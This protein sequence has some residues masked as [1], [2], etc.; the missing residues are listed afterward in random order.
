MVC[1]AVGQVGGDTK[2]IIL[3]IGVAYAW[4]CHLGV[5]Q[6]AVWG[7]FRLSGLFVSLA[8]RVNAKNVAPWILKNIVIFGVHGRPPRLRA[9]P[10]CH[11]EG[12]W[13]AL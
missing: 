8:A 9:S 10:P 12:T 5:F 4:M 2:E 11:V 13:Q 7:P 1:G 3:V 6:K